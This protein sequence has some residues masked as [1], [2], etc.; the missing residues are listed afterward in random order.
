MA[1]LPPAVQTPQTGM[2][3]PRKG[4][5]IEPARRLR[6]LP[7]RRTVSCCASSGTRNPAASRINCSG[8]RGATR[9]RR[10]KPPRCVS[11]RAQRRLSSSTAVHDLRAS[12]KCTARREMGAARHRGGRQAQLGIR[13][14]VGVQPTWVGERRLRIPIG[15]QLPNRPGW[16][17]LSAVPS[18][19]ASMTR[20]CQGQAARSRSFLQPRASG[21]YTATGL[22]RVVQQPECRCRRAPGRLRVVRRHERS[23][24]CWRRARL[25]R[26]TFLSAP[27]QI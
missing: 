18:A 13:V 22:G 8:D 6:V 20:W 12:A 1:G 25:A 17:R 27:I 5:V 4:P 21:S 26:L 9:R 15:A 24:G 23:A 3:K 14:V 16:Q 7:T 10:P 19:T 11:L 2:P